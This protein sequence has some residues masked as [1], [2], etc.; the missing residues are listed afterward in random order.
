ML[1]KYIRTYIT[2]LKYSL[3]IEFEYKTNFALDSLSS[4][5]RVL[6]FWIF[7]EI[8][9]L[10]VDSILGW[11]KY[12]MILIYGFFRLLWSIFE[13]SIFFNMKEFSDKILNGSID[14][15]LLK[16]IN[17]IFM[18]TFYKFKFFRLVKALTGLILIVYS[19][20]KITVYINFL[21]IVILIYC[22]V[23]LFIIFHSILLS[24][25]S[26]T[27]WFGRISH[28]NWIIAELGNIAK[29]PINAYQNV[30]K[31]IFVFLVPYTLFS[32]I[33]AAIILSRINMNYLLYETFIAV[34]WVIFANWF[35]NFS[36]Q[37]YQSEGG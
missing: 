21:N 5:F 13:C 20:Q 19:L 7:I 24:Y 37:R 28:G 26:L 18:V 15:V 36:L 33:P 8:I 2:L 35:W 14:F 30:M 10:N 16:P 22:A 27:F 9:Y 1:T 23:L 3:Q 11:N 6:S 34:L 25:L 4:V 17:T 29:L 32:S 12:E 31:I